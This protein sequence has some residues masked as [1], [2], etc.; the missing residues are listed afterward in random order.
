MT[1]TAKTR[2]H[3]LAETGYATYTTHPIN[4]PARC[5]EWPRAIAAPSLDW[6]KVQAGVVV[7]R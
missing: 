1:R 7:R 2:P 4:R 5:L 6:L 3:S